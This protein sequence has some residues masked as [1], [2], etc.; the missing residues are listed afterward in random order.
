MATRLLNRIR[1]SGTYYNTGWTGY[2]TMSSRNLGGQ[3]VTAA[4]DDRFGLFIEAVGNNNLWEVWVA[5][6]NLHYFEGIEQAFAIAP[7]RVVARSE[8]AIPNL[9]SVIITSCLP[10]VALSDMLSGG[11]TVDYFMGPAFWE[12]DETVTY[13]AGYY[14]PT[15][16]DSVALRRV[17]PFNKIM[18]DT[19]R[20]EVYVD[21]EL[22]SQAEQIYLRALSSDGLAAYGQSP[23]LGSAY[24][25]DAWN[26]LHIDSS[27]TMY[28]QTARLDVLG[29]GAHPE[30]IKIRNIF[31]QQ[32]FE[33]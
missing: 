5:Y 32:Y 27:H 9:S 30:L 7:D 28:S 26:I 21:S 22:G 6:C 12:E 25:P 8:T 15:S 4:E 31:F 11:K 3:V 2:V 18:T 20:C 13:E 14:Q 1:Q 24:T 23:P 10:E 33:E 17:F 19:C 16:E 29:Y